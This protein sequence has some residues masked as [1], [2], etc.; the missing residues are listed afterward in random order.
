MSETTQLFED[1]QPEEPE[2]PEGGKRRGRPPG[3]PKPPKKRQYAQE[4]I[5]L[6]ARVDMALRMLNRLPPA[7]ADSLLALAIDTLKGAE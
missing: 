3:S 6:Q 1:V 5:E 2:K 4:L 7:N